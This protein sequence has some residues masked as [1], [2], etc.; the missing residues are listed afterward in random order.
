[1]IPFVKASAYGNDFLII[2]ESSVSASQRHEVTR[3]LCHRTT[4]V[5][6][7]GVEW[8]APG[9]VGESDTVATLINADG[10]DAEVSGNG[11]RC[12]AAYLVQRSP[13]KRHLGIATGAGVKGCE[14]VS[15]HEQTYTFA[16]HMGQVR[17][18]ADREASGVNGT[19]V[20]LGNPH[21]VV[22]VDTLPSNWREIARQVQA[23]SAV[24]PRGV[25]V[26]FVTVHSRASLSA[27]FYERGAGETSSSG[28]G[29][30]ASAVA[31]HHAQ[32]TNAHVE[33]RA[34]GG[35]QSV[36]LRNDGIVLHGS[37]SLICAGEA[38]L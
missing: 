8:L 38:W 3:K 9:V 25:N 6:A 28:T 32:L 4:G 36:E 29:T 24:F 10:S 13:A 31:A 19:F 21:F 20:D 33:V 2:E 35:A 18:V 37:A 5:G 7:D 16:M 11:T 17:E 14:L 34:P 27:H 23:C 30:C 12:V 15:I 1:M 26:E 22:F